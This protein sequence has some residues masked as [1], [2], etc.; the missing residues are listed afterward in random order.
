MSNPAAR[1]VPG[2]LVPL[3]QAHQFPCAGTICRATLWTKHMVLTPSYS[4][5]QEKDFHAGVRKPEES[6]RWHCSRRM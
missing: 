3:N 4:R 2:N 6:S 5:A 1:A